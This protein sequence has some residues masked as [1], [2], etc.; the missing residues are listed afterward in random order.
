MDNYLA[1]KLLQHVGHNI[2]IAVYGDGINIYDVCIECVDCN[3]V[4]IDCN[5]DEDDEEEYDRDSRFP[6]GYAEIEYDNF[7]DPEATLG[8]RFDDINFMRYFEK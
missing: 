3:E 5:Y 8:A 2:E 7:D 1:K 6:P 4:L